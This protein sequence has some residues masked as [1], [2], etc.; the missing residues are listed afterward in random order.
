M[1]G[2]GGT[3]RPVLLT[4]AKKKSHLECLISFRI[5]LSLIK[6]TLKKIDIYLYKL[7][8][9]VSHLPCLMITWGY[10]IVGN[11]SA[12]FRTMSLRQGYI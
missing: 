8:D 6:F 10:N 11:V 7:E 4:G 3:P 12:A 1:D 5:S 2:G 9:E